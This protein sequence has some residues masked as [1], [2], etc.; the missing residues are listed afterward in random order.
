MTRMVARGIIGQNEG[1]N[2]S[3][4]IPDD[5]DID[6]DNDG[7]MDPNPQFMIDLS[8][9]AGSILG[10]QASMMSGY[11]LHRMQI[12]IRPVD[13]VNDN[14][15]QAT[16]AGD[17][18]YYPVTNHTIEAL[19]LARRVEKA[20]EANQ[21]DGDS[22]FLSNDV[23]YSGFRYAWSTVNKAINH[24]TGNGITGMNSD[25]V[26]SEIF[27]AYDFMTEPKQS[28]ALFGGRAPENMA[29]AWVCSWNAGETHPAAMVG[30]G[31]DFQVN[32]NLKI[33]PLILGRVN[34]SSGDEPG[35]VDDDYVVE[36]TV[37]FTPEF[38]GV[39]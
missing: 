21:V 11:K 31:T 28:N 5:G 1:F 8:E 35:T 9:L 22:L 14:D 10:Y 27:D 19:Q 12:G 34:Y 39:F 20:D 23:D 6:A 3:H 7:V 2:W 32:H 18:I 4:N 30:G 25:W 33:L 15:S 17:F 29:Q 24:I 36:V 38:G 13:D 26:L 16:F 37:E